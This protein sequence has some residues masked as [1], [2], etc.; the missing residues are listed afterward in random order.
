[1]RIRYTPSPVLLSSYL[2]YLHDKKKQ[3]ENSVK[4]EVS[5]P[6][7]LPGGDVFDLSEDEEDK[8]TI[9]TEYDRLKELVGMNYTLS[10]VNSDV[11]AL[12]IALSERLSGPNKIDTLSE[13]IDKNNVFDNWMS[14][15]DLRMGDIDIP[16]KKEITR[17]LLSRYTLELYVPGKNTEEDLI[18]M[19]RSMKTV[20]FNSEVYTSRAF[21]IFLNQDDID[22]LYP[23]YVIAVPDSVKSSNYT[24]EYILPVRLSLNRSDK[25]SVIAKGFWHLFQYQNYNE[26]FMDRLILDNKILKDKPSIKAFVRNYL[27]KLRFDTYRMKN[28]TNKVGQEYKKIDHPSIRK[29]H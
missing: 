24:Y 1:M 20:N 16:Y 12:R 22:K 28:K 19:S 15:E 27:V 10:E 18:K 13:L 23:N 14:D 5:L 21:N 3:V 9:A 25:S 29:R 17:Y 8:R 26:N 4:D 11:S 6:D 7:D 2:Y